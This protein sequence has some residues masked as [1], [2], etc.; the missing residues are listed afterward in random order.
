MDI[1]IV[2][3]CCILKNIHRGVGNTVTN[4]VIYSLTFF[5]NAEMVG[6]MACERLL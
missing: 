3:W 6:Q 4:T 1:V 2:V 5:I